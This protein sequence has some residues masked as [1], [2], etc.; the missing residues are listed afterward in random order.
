MA[1]SM[2]AVLTAVITAVVS[3]C[4]TLVIV[5]YT[6]ESGVQKEAQVEIVHDDEDND[7]SIFFEPY[8]LVGGQQSAE[9]DRSVFIVD[10]KS[11]RISCDVDDENKKALVVTYSYTNNSNESVPMIYAASKVNAY[12]NGVALS[13]VSFVYGVE[14]E[15]GSEYR[16]TNVRP[17]TTADIELCYEINDMNEDIFVEVIS[18]RTHSPDFTVSRT[19]EMK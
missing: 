18:N 15:T 14:D 11:A 7:D 9:G 5:K 2:V 1:K 4:S 13:N 17:G 8:E 3:V 16:Y 10:I 19:F 6:D 12:Q